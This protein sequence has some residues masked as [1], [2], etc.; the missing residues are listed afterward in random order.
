MGFVIDEA[1]L[2]AVLSVGPMSDEAFVQLC[3]EHPDL[4]LEMSAHG[5]LILMPLRQTWMGAVNAEI[6]GQ[7]SNWARQNKRGVAFDSST[8]WL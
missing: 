8:G 5:Q 4:N 1:H 7:L 2:P 3:S 6:S